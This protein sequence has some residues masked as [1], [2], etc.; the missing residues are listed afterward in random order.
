MSKYS[1]KFKEKAVEA[2]L[3]GEGGKSARTPYTIQQM[4]VNVNEF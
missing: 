2:C 1:Y 3:N 4:Q